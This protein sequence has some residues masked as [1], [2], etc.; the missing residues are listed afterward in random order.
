MALPSI[1]MASQSFIAGLLL[2]FSEALE[3]LTDALSAPEALEAFLGD[4]GWTLDPGSTTVEI[5]QAFGQL[6]SALTEVANLSATLAQ[7]NASPQN[8]QALVT[9]IEN[10]QPAVQ[11]L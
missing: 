4:L 3:P 5:V 9:A 7:A 6:P 10:V 8:N 1:L 2:G 11:S